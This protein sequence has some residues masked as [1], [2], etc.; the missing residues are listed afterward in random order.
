MTGTLS[1][2]N[3]N[4]SQLN[5][6]CMRAH[7]ELSASSPVNSKLR[8]RQ[9]ANYHKLY[10]FIKKNIDK[11]A[12]EIANNPAGV[13]F[14]KSYSDTLDA[15]ARKKPKYEITQNKSGDRLVR[16]LDDAGKTKFATKHGA[17]HL[18]LSSY[19]ITPKMNGYWVLVCLFS[20]RSE[21]FDLFV[22]YQDFYAAKITKDHLQTINHDAF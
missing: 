10:L 2:K 14:F 21:E 7:N 4:L 16:F 9:E 5:S 6:L 15:I 12:L 13:Y 3:L 19:G 22:A 18:I 17:A 11:I 20:F 8:Q 1:R